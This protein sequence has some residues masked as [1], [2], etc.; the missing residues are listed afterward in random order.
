MTDIYNET[1]HTTV[2]DEPHTVEY[3]QENEFY[4]EEFTDHEHIA[5]E[6]KTGKQRVVYLSLILLVALL[7]AGV[8]IFA[9]I[10]YVESVTQ[11]PLPLPPAVQT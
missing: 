6:T 3:A 11:V 2:Y 4:G 8:L 1:Y 5:R 9:V 10:P 7:L